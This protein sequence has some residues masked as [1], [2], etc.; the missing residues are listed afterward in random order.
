MVEFDRR[1]TGYKLGLKL[2]SMDSAASK[3]V[4][5]IKQADPLLRG[6]TD[7]TD[8]TW[9]LLVGDGREALC[10]RRFDGTQPI[11]VLIMETGKHIPFNCGA[12]PR[13]LLAHLP[14]AQ[15]EMV[16][17]AHTQRSTKYSLVVGRDELERDR[18]EVREG[19]YA[20]GWEDCALHACGLGTPV[21]VAGGRGGGRSEHLGDC[22]AVLGRKVALAGA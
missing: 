6:I 10:L 8:E 5:L 3:S 15:W 11:R 21:R 19:G 20:V 1:T 7:E 9:L 14:E 12:A 16:V 17:A 4:E 13:V 2:F 18:N 22:G